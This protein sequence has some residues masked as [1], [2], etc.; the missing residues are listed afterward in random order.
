MMIDGKIETK[1]LTQ[2]A[3]QKRKFLSTEANQ[4][5]GLTSI[6]MNDRKKD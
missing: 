5:G 6:Q 4:S 1:M 2:P 3:K